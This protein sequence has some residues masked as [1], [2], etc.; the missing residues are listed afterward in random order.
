MVCRRKY[1]F[2]LGMSN[3]HALVVTGVVRYV[4]NWNSQTFDKY[5]LNYNRN[6]VWTLVPKHNRCVGTEPT[7]SV[8][9][10]VVNVE[11]NRSSS[12][13]PPTPCL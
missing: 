11:F 5:S 10:C 12:F 9:V 6:N 2:L 13:N 3:A 4:Y 1:F 7:L 8:R